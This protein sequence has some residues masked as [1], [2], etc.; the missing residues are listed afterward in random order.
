MKTTLLLSLTLLFSSI[1]FSQ[2]IPATQ[3]PEAVIKSFNK[4]FPNSPK[5]EWE[6]KASQYEAEF[7]VKRAEHKAL[8]DSNGQLIVFKRDIPHSQLPQAVKQAIKLQYPQYKIDKTE[9]IARKGHLYYQVELDGKPQ[10][11]KV[12]FTRDGQT[13][14]SK[15]W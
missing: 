13:D 2:D 5:V 7:D 12:V 15:G 14:N 10:D 11:L 9:R 8:F 3:V 4:Y 6:K 1:V